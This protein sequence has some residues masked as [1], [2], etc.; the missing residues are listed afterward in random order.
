MSSFWITGLVVTATYTANLVTTLATEK[1]EV[2]YKTLDDVAA[3]DGFT[4]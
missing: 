1:P 3:D 4:L 2:P